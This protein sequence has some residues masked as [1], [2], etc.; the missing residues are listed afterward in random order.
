[1]VAGYW[2]PNFFLWLI[3]KNR[4]L[5]KFKIQG[6]TM[7]PQPLIKD[8]IKGN[9]LGTLVTIPLTS[10]L[11]YKM[12]SVGKPNK[13]PIQDKLNKTAEE[14]EEEKNAQHRVGWSNLRFRGTSNCSLWDYIWMISVGYFVYDFGFYW[15]HR[16]LHTSTFYK[17]IHSTHHKF[18]A[19]VGVAASY[20]HPIE[21]L[22]QSLLWHLPIALAGYM[23]GDLPPGVFCA[24][25]VFRW[26]ETVDAH[27][28]YSLPFSPFTLL[29]IFGGAAHHDDHHSM[30]DGNFGASVIW[31]KLFGTAMEPMDK[32]ALS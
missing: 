4:W 9:L 8:E 32:P 24:Y 13:P 31:D 15:M 12:Y 26:L 17:K 1:M 5:H 11:F 19:T 14:E 30:V 7:P 3:W 10:F 6:D 2:I 16:T 28:G 25:S 22:L 21:N 27:C 20:A 29:P 18:Y 23:K